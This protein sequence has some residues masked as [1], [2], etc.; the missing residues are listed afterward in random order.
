MIG[1]KYARIERL[2]KL[3]DR[4]AYFSLILDICIAVITSLSI[5]HIGNSEIILVPVN[6][7]L[8]IVV[9]LSIGLFITLFMLKHEE[10]ILDKLLNRNYRYKPKRRS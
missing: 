2:K 9:I 10:G 1:E 4:I 5:F 6:Y 8:T 3:I 7:L